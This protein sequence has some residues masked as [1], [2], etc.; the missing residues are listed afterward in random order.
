MET[1]F[2]LKGC[3]NSCLGILV[4]AMLMRS[5]KAKT[6]V[7]GGHISPVIWALRMHAV[8]TTPCGWCKHKSTLLLPVFFTFFLHFRSTDCYTMGF[9]CFSLWKQDESKG[10]KMY[11]QRSSS[12]SDNLVQRWQQPE[13]LQSHRGGREVT[14][15]RYFQSYYHSLYRAVKNSLE[16]TTALETVA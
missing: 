11:V 4:Y 7:S 2:H 10:C 16:Y 15:Q 5:N 8:M 12:T 9:S 1:R 14:G 3:I 13:N 6:A